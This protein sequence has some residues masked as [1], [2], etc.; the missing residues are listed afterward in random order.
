MIEGRTSGAWKTCDTVFVT[1]KKVL[2]QDSTGQKQEINAKTGVQSKMLLLISLPNQI[3]IKREAIGTD[4]FLEGMQDRKKRGEAR[5]ID[6]LRKDKP[7]NPGPQVQP[8]EL[9]PGK[10]HLEQNCLEPF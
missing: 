10:T 2:N 5:I 7:Q 9:G 1:L 8:L 6:F 3:Q 4:V